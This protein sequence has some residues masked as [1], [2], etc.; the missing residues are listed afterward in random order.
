ME[1]AMLDVMYD[2]PS[3]SG[4]QECVINEQVITKGDY[5]VVLYQNPSEEKL[6]TA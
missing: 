4:V 5:P 2:L 1:V 3:K 6:Q